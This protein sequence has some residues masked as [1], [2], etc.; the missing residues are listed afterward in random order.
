MTELEGGW[1]IELHFAR[2]DHVMRLPLIDKLAVGR[3]EGND[4]A[5]VGFDLSGLNASD[6]GVSRR[7][8]LFTIQS[9]YIALTDLNSSN[10]TY[11]NGVKLPP[12]QPMRVSDKDNLRFGHL[13]AT[14]GVR[15]NLG[16]TS[17]LASTI[18]IN[19]GSAPKVGRGQRILMVEDDTSTSDLIQIV[20]KRAGYVV[21][22]SRDVVSAIRHINQLG[23]PALVIIDLLLPSIHG[24]ELCRY[25]RRDTKFPTIP[26]MVMSALVDKNNV[27]QAMD[28][29]ADVYLSKPPNLKELVRVV[30][31]MVRRSDDNDVQNKGTRRFETGLIDSAKLPRTTATLG[32]AESILPNILLLFV[33]GHQEP[34]TVLVNSVIT[35]GRLNRDTGAFRGNG[36]TG[37][38]QTSHIDLEPYGAYD[39]GVSRVHARLSYDDDG[40]FLEDLGST[41][42]TMIGEQVLMPNVPTPLPH[43]SEIMIGKL[44]M[45]VFWLLPPAKRKADEQDPAALQE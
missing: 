9:D 39:K 26:I 8:A 44:K 12:D 1:I 38:G 20:L 32:S 14:I 17:I 16:T 28:A 2:Q 24:L 30:A 29:G 43:D 15:E 23:A 33:Q 10:G 42:K 18:E 34:I 41:N 4:Q 37:K 36:A 45:N 40:F 35:L 27:T 5:I 21:H 22:A 7:H 25:I 31:A 11:I 3:T 13:T 19:F 6:L